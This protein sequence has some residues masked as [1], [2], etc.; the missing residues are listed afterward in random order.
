MK[1]FRMQRK[2]FLICDLIVRFFRLVKIAEKFRLIVNWAYKP[3]FA[4]AYYACVIFFANKFINFIMHCSIA[5]ISGLTVVPKIVTI[6]I[7]FKIV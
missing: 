4:S 5:I 7:S 1:L 6:F 3:N 2:F